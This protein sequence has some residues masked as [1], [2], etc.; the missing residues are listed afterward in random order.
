MSA[1]VLSC[2]AIALALFQISCQKDATAQTSNNYTLPPAT[3]SNLGGVIVGNGLSIS[4]NGNLSVNTSTSGGIVQQNKII[5]AKSK[6]SGSTFIVEIW[7]AKYDGSSASKVNITLPAGVIFA[8]G[9]NPAISP[10]GTKIFF[11]GATSL[12]NGADLYSCNADGT[13]V[14]KIVD[15]A[16][17]GIIL[18][19]AY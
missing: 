11:T 10:D 2:F 5:F 16:G 18:G 8:D 6:P 7:T 12:L 19:G 3:T 13:N 1:I 9:I 17:G 15:R 14:V 4:S